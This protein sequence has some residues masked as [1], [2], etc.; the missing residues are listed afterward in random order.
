MPWSGTSDP[1]E[2]SLDILDTSL[3]WHRHFQHPVMRYPR[4]AR[5][6]AYKRMPIQITG[7]AERRDLPVAGAWLGLRLGQFAGDQQLGFGEKPLILCVVGDV[8]SLHHLTEPSHRG[9]S[10]S[11]LTK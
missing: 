11:F 7:G 2:P 4:V 9:A 5:L 1:K 10:F 8:R 3:P 6:T